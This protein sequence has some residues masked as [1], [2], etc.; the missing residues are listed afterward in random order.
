MTFYWL[1]FVFVVLWSGLIAVQELDVLGR[2]Q[3]LRCG[4]RFVLVLVLSLFAGLFSESGSVDYN[5]YVDMLDVDPP[6]TAWE[7][8]TLKDPFFLLMGLFLKGEDGNISLLVFLLA[9]VSL[10]IKFKIFSSVFGGSEYADIYGLAVIFLVGRFFLLHEFTQ[11]RASLGIALVSLSIVYAMQNRPVAVVATAA[12]AALTHLSILALLPAVLLVYRVDL[13]V[14]LYV[15]AFA[16]VAA[17]AVVTLFDV[18]RFSRLTPY[19]TGEYPVT[20][21]TLF[22]VYFLFKVTLLAGLL[23]QWKSLPTAIRHAVVISAYGIF[24]TWL[25]LQNDVLS[26]RLGELTAV[27]DCLCF[28]YFFRRGLTL[29]PVYGYIAGVGIAVLFYFS[30]IHIVNPLSLGF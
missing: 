11:L 6:A 2:A 21:N 3:A 29:A 26:L 23:L 17:L 19:L 16:V 13:K 22:S 20:N 5:N 1:L 12:L 27:F 18:E 30:S 14:K 28:A 8:V 7:A 25:F 4:T 9:F 24:L 10:G 15:T